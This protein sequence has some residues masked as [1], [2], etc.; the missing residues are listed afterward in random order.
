MGSNGK[1]LFIT[2]P[3]G[4]PGWGTV[5]FPL[6][7]LGKHRL[8]ILLSSRAEILSKVPDRAGLGIPEAICRGRYITDLFTG[9]AGWLRFSLHSAE[10][11]AYQ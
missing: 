9:G 4:K 5:V 11:C 1:G 10:F 8:S 2:S 6:Y 3:T 7:R